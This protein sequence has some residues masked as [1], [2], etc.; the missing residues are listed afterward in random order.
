MESCYANSVVLTGY[1]AT[2][3]PCTSVRARILYK[4]KAGVKFD[5]RGVVMKDEVQS[6][7]E[8]NEALS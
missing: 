6:S 8:S 7:S 5:C 2:I 3:F 1:N 4:I